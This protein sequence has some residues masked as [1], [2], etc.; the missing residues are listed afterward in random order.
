MTTA[1]HTQQ[2]AER[3]TLTL[4]KDNAG[5]PVEGTVVEHQGSAVATRPAWLTAAQD[6]VLANRMY[7]PWVARGYWR[8]ASRWFAGLRDDY[9]QM[10]RT[11]KADRK[12]ADGDSAAEAKAH[13]LVQDRRAAYRKHRL[14]YSL[15]TGGWAT[16]A[17]TSV[18]VTTLGAPLLDVP[19]ALA[20][21]GLGAWHGRP[22]K[23]AI[24]N[25]Q[26]LFAQSAE[27]GVQPRSASSEELITALVNAKIIAE[28]QRDETRVV[29]DIRP[30]GP[31]WSAT[32]E[33]PRGMEAT[34][35]IAKLGDLAS[36]L[37][38]K[39][40]RIEIK[41][42]T[43]AEGHEGR[44]T[45]WVA[46]SD[47][48][49]SGPK[50][51]SQLIQ[52]GQWD[53]WEHGVP[54]GLDARGTR[55]SL[56]LL[57][58][59]LL[60]GG[61]QDY[62][63]SYLARL[64]A[65]AAALDPTV[66]IVLISGKVSPDWLPL[67]EIAHKYVVGADP[68]AVRKV[69]D[70]LEETITDM[71]GVGAELTRLYREEPARCPEGKLTKELTQRPGLGPTLVIVEELQE[72]LD[73]AALMKVK[74][75]DDE[76]GEGARSRPAKE[77]MVESMA[78]FVRVA[79]FAGGMG[80]F[81]TQRPDSNS[82]P[83]ALREVCVKRASFR[84]KGD[85]SAKMVLGNDAVMNGAAPHLLTEASKGVFVLDQ[86][87]EEGHSTQRGDVIDLPEFLAICKRGRQLRTDAG[88]LTGY[89]AQRGKPIEVPPEVQLV[90]AAVRVMREAGVDRMRTEDLA[91][92]LGLEAGK[93]R[94]LMEKAGAGKP[95]G[96]GEMPGA[97]NPR[98]YKLDTLQA[99]VPRP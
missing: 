65:A 51:Y 79:R 54:L 34:D 4:V 31:G 78:R 2:D 32:I 24:D 84:V 33:L 71:Q 6:H 43:S 94:D 48:P 36:S 89:A 55:V 20:A 62:G 64:V 60:I 50:V 73:A 88:T 82:V 52:A 99:L 30:D 15:K 67:E 76:D 12:N 41:A 8:L 10:I 22:E 17:G 11:A 25:G 74:T 27:A 16:A 61:L 96:L 45:M 72:L 66:R 13:A 28:A 47:N 80:M 39:K 18:T 69:L 35:A 14:F 19:L 38:I 81:I 95:G 93:L 58:S 56:P 97:K 26:P 57:W 1:A 98:G 53:F 49:Y 42:D 68:D 37:R 63:K 46:S 70:V 77:V 23:T 92:E 7:A 87:A 5:Q 44:F 59:S 90:T 83:T 3:P 21:L 40:Q 91:K 29:G 85:T 9:P 75:S 86:G